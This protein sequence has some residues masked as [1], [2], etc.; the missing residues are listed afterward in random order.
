VKQN[1]FSKGAGQVFGD[2]PIGAKQSGANTSID[3]RHNVER[4]L[5][6][7]LRTQVG[8]RIDR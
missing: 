6:G 1:I 5:D 8:H 7:T 4:L 2:L 3:K